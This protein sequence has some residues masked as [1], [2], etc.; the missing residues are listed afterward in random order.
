M[1]EEFIRLDYPLGV[2]PFGLIIEIIKN[3]FN[4]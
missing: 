4:K 2:S 3:V 1:N